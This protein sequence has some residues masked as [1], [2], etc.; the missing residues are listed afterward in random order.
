[1]KY[2]AYLFI[3]F[4]IFIILS[5]SLGWDNPFFPLVN[6]IPFGDKVMHVILLGTFAFCANV[7]LRFHRFKISKYQLLTGSVI[8]FLLATLEEISQYW[9]PTRTFDLLDLTANYIGILLASFFILKYH[10]AID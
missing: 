9:I 2:F 10:K 8:I 7:L 3:V 5:A 1:M 4:V 6:K